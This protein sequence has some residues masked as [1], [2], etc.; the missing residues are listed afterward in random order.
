MSALEFN[1]PYYLFLLIPYTV[2]LFW[3]IFRKINRRESAI[4]VSSE[5]LMPQRHSIRS[6]TYPYLP[7]LR[8]CALLLIIIAI[9][10]PGRGVHF[11]SIKNQGIDIVIAMDVSGSMMAEDFQPKNRLA[12]AKEVIIDFIKRRTTDRLGMVIFAGET[13]LQCPLTVEH[14]IINDLVDEIDFKT[15]PANGTA[16]G[17]AIALSTARLI[18]SKAK[19]KVILLVTD[20]RNNTGTIDPETA[21]KAASEQGVKIYTIGIGKKGEP[22]PFPTNIPMVKQKIMSDLDDESLIKIAETTGGKFYNATS[23]GVLWKNFQD[24]DRLERAEVE[25]KKYHEFYD[26]FHWLLY[27]AFGLFI[28]EVA[29]RSIFYRKIP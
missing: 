17:D 6:A 15:I 11:S 22:V 29:L 2:M 3:Y 7:V 14:S 24:I 12:V 9:A 16:V 23:A 21:A 25:L 28:S 5:K 26:R 8:F 27:I 4:A 1:N 10:R 18:D 20:G 13:Y 19:S